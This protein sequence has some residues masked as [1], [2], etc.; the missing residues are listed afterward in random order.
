MSAGGSRFCLSGRFG[1][2]RGT[3]AAAR[4]LQRGERARR[5]GV[6]PGARATAG[7]GRR[8][9]RRR[10]AGAGADGAHRRTPCVVLRDY[11]HTPDAL[12]RA[13][14]SLRPLTPG[15]AHR[16]LRLRRRPRPRQ[17]PA[18]GAIAGRLADVAIVTSDNPRTEDPEAIL[19]DIEEGM[20]GG[21][22][23]ADRGPAR[24][25]PR[26]AGSGPAGRHRPARRQGAR[27]LPD[28]RHREGALRRAGDRTARGAGSVS[29][30]PSRPGH[31]AMEG[32]RC[33][34]GPG[35]AA[36]R[37]DRVFTTISTDTR[38]IPAGRA[39]RGAGGRAVRWARLSRRR[40]S[41][42]R[43][44]AVVREG[45]PA[46]AGLRCC[47]CRTHSGRSACW[48]GRGDRAH[49]P[50]R[51]HHRHQRKDQHQGDAGRRAGHPLRHLRHP[52]QSQQPGRRAAHHPRGSREY[53]G[54][55]G[56]GGGQPAR[57]RSPAIAR[58]SSP[59]SWWSPMRWRDTSRG[60]GRWP[61]CWRRSCRSPM[62]SPPRSSAPSRPRSPLGRAGAAAKVRTAG[63]RGADLVPDRVE[64]GPDAQAEADLR[65]DLVLA[66]GTGTAPGRQRGAGLGRGRG[67]RAR[68]RGG[69][70]RA[71]AVRPARWPRRAGPIRRAHDPER[72]LQ[73]QPAILPLR[74]RHCGRAPGQAAAG[75][76][77]R[78]HARAGRRLRRAPR[79]DR[80]GAR[81][82][83]ARTC[84]RPS[85]SSFRRWRRTPRRWATGC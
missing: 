64:L 34:G 46:V 10:A 59:T 65:R 58:S 47:P 73:R 53:R 77:R 56:R 74:D 51:R 66:R 8:A 7:R 40:G 72:L 26:R 50:G 70:P 80:A 83:R 19:D 52:G 6:R 62:A 29:G 61:G 76:R 21:D 63:L 22:A 25:D 71:R 4:R 13:L 5:R 60:S 18:D 12:E 39:V 30:A 68:P 44:G 41:R 35:L 36:S 55:G 82:A 20:A 37:R 45:T 69:R 78:H 85:A 17:A 67:A 14:A 31:S 79:G 15:T 43:R 1:T 42:G 2:R 9:A 27:D 75:V 48:R 49:R 33:P 23:P 11:A 32:S 3:A 38:D 28:H 54:A 84:S 16:R 81:G 24:G 57:A